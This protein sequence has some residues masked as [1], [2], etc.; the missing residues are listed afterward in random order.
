M[1][2]VTDVAARMGETLRWYSR[3]L[4]V[5]LL[6]KKPAANGGLF[7]AHYGC[8]KQSI[9]NNVGD[10]KLFL[11]VLNPSTLKSVHLALVEEVPYPTTSLL[12]ILE[13][14]ARLRPKKRA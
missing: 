10:V 12:E 13:E 6:E 7:L 2:G 8:R 14:P 3:F 11:S 1:I 5:N 9:S 4:H